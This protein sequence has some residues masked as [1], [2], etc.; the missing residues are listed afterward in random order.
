MEPQSPLLRPRSP[1]AEGAGLGP[2]SVKWGEGVPGGHAVGVSGPLA[3]R[4]VPVTCR[5]LHVGHKARGLTCFSA[6]G[7]PLGSSSLGLSQ[8][9]A[10]RFLVCHFL[11]PGPGPSPGRLGGRP[12]CGAVLLVVGLVYVHLRA[13]QGSAARPCTLPVAAHG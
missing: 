4:G 2:A 3:R 10:L 13:V 6:S 7:G 11:G 5:F 8:P 9:S 1:L 12:G